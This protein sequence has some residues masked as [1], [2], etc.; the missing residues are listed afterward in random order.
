MAILLGVALTSCSKE[1]TIIPQTKK[2]T[3]DYEVSIKDLKAYYANRI[4]V[5]ITDLSYNEE[6]Q[7]FSL[8]GVDQVSREK[9]TEFYKFNNQ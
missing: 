8:W 4:N 2:V 6:T 7:Q 9:L 5:K 3:P 1:E